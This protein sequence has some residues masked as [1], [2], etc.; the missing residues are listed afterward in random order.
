MLTHGIPVKRF[1]FR[2]MYTSTKRLLQVDLISIDSTV[3]VFLK[4]AV[5]KL[6]N[7]RLHYFE[8]KQ[9]RF[10]EAGLD[11]VYQYSCWTD[12]YEPGLPDHLAYCCGFGRDQCKIQA[13]LIVKSFLWFILIHVFAVQLQCIQ[14][15]LVVQ[16]EL[17]F[18]VKTIWYNLDVF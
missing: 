12:L 15:L 16:W 6:Y 13:L 9:D 17:C 10:H 11:H 1:H 3:I 14:L 18:W 4:S 8:I 5:R 2:T 7:Y